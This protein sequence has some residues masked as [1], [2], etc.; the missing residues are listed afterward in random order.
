[1]RGLLNRPHHALMCGKAMRDAI[2]LPSTQLTTGAAFGEEDG[3]NVRSTSRGSHN[4]VA[5]SK[6]GRLSLDQDLCESLTPKSCYG[7]FL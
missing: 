4:L 7:N 1:M 3:L 5:S 2:R 6:H